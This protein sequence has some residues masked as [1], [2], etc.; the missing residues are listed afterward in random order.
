MHPEDHLETLLL[1]AAETGAEVSASNSLEFLD[2]SELDPWDSDVQEQMVQKEALGSTER[3]TSLEDATIAFAPWAVHC[4]L[5]RRSALNEDRL[6]IPQLDKFASEDTAFWFRVLH[7]RKVAYTGK[8]TALYRIETW[9]YRNRADELPFWFDAVEHYVA[10]NLEF[11]E[12][13]GLV[14]N[15]RQHESLTRLWENLYKRALEQDD[16]VLAERALVKANQWLCSTPFND[17]SL[18]LKLR[19]LVGISLFRRFMAL[20]SKGS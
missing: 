6:W 16:Q 20:R 18:S 7:G 3:A 19:R 11:L 1:S 10:T 14:P 12:G 17:L 5:V 13:L 8:Y 4:A 9:N 2:G 15:R